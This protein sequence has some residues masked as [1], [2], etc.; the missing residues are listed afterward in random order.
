[1]FISRLTQLVLLSSVEAAGLQ[2]LGRRGRFPQEGVNFPGHS[3]SPGPSGPASRPSVNFPGSTSYKPGTETST[4]EPPSVEF[5]HGIVEL[6]VDAALCS[7][8]P[9]VV[10]LCRAS[11][12]RW[13]FSPAHGCFKFRYGGCGGNSNRF[14]TEAQCEAACPG[15]T[16]GVNEDKPE[17]LPPVSPPSD[18]FGLHGSS[19]KSVCRTTSGPAAGKRCVFPFTWKG[20]TYH[21]CT[22]EGDQYGHLWCSTSTGGNHVSGH[23]EY[24]VCSKACGAGGP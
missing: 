9:R 16:H 17:P 18:R 23:G 4:T 8:P 21:S 14:L 11:V 19:K 6:G 2:H 15:G 24:G 7:L 3:S 10:G 13:T 1:M 22:R 20:R 12:P 5:D